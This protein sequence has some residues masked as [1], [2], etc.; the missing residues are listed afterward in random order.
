MTVRLYFIRN[1]YGV[2]VNEIQ[3][4]G[5]SEKRFTQHSDYFNE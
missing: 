4:A 3:A 1:I 2:H 5:G